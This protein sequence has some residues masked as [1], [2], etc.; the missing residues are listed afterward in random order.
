MIKSIKVNFSRSVLLL[1]FFA[2]FFCL[3]GCGG[4][5]D[6]AATSDGT[7]TGTETKTASLTLSVPSSVMFGTPVTATAT[8]RDANGALVSGAV[9]TFA[10]SSDLITFTPTSATALTNASGGAS[11]TVNS[12]SIAS[13]G[14]TS[15]TASAP[16][17]TNGTTSTV[18][19][20]P[21]G[22]SVG[23]ATV[24][25]G[26]LTFGASSISAYGTSS[27]SVPVLIGGL[28]AIIPISVTFTSSCVASE[29]ATITSP[30]TSNSVTGIATS[31]YKDNNCNSGTD[32]ITA[33]VTGGASASATI[34]V[35]PPATNN[36]QF[37][38]ATPEIIATQTVGSATLP[39]SSLVKFKVV[40]NNNNGKAGVVV[41]F[42]LIGTTLLG[43]IT[44]SSSSATSDTDGY[45]ITSVTSGTT[46]TPVWVLATV[47]GSSP[48]IS[49]QSNRLTITTGL[50]AQNAFSLSVSTFNIEGWIYDGTTS[51][52]TITASDRLGN[53]VP[54]GTAINFITP[55][56][57]QINSA[58]C[59]TASGTCTTTFISANPR[60][61][62]GRV[63]VLAYAVGEMSFV[64]ANGDNIYNAGE[65][66][67]DLG[68]LY[69]DYNENHQWDTGE[70]FFTPYASAGISAC[71]TRPSGNPLPAS[72]GYDLNVLS[73]E[74]TCSTAWGINYVR[75]SAVITFSGSHASI[76]KN[77]FTTA[78]ACFAVYKFFLKDENNNPMPAGTNVSI[79]SALSNMN[80]TLYA[81]QGDP[82]ELVKVAAPA[83]LD[84]AGSPVLNTNAVGGS[85][86]SLIINGGAGCI[87]AETAGYGCTTVGCLIKY[88][89]GPVAIDVTTPKGNI[90][91]MSI[92]IA[93]DPLLTYPA[94]GSCPP[95]P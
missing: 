80:Y 65:T 39:K 86:V 16:V 95:S 60:P 58:S 73:K 50:P 83:T 1:I 20:T 21:V 10:A 37:V 38:S 49:S 19:S 62:D 53:P 40:D 29:K 87:A 76:S 90:T 89:F 11:I 17:T 22:I 12:A 82:P 67:Y 93:C 45:V 64:D 72:Y 52:L 18:T 63:T 26:A 47:H 36:I 8:L 85:E 15:I 56:G 57:A 5:Q 32:T 27:V 14:A 9:V 24:T 66:F 28:P 6:A 69:V 79:N 46:P 59:I 34:T 92:S 25:L 44:L 71:M 2:L 84:V 7:G 75:Q 48:V 88:P 74:T 55:E 94:A 41:D 78:N 43:G 91:T 30:I 31:T 42:S 51:T 33:S 35:V 54:D 4:S 13:A 77:E 68:N 70:Q 23:G 61:A 3:S 81:N